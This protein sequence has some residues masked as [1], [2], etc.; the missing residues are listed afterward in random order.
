MP[1]LKFEQKIEERPKSTEERPESLEE[2]ELKYASKAVA[3][4]MMLE[5]RGEFPES[6]H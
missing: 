2:S 4:Q 3:V 1:E 5:A 6:F